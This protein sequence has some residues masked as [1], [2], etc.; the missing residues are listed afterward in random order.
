MLIELKNV[1]L[2]MWEGSFLPEALKGEDGKIQKDDKGKIIN[3]GR[4]I[5]YTIYTF[6]DLFGEVIKIMTLN[7]TYRQFENQSVVVTLDLTR[8]EFQGKSEWRGAIKSVVLAE[9]SK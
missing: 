5:E 9:K 1:E 2:K 6:R 7:S 4:K 8:K 3:T